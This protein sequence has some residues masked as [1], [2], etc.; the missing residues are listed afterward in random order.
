[1]YYHKVKTSRGEEQV[2]RTVIARQAN[3]VSCLSDQQSEAK[4]TTHPVPDVFEEVVDVEVLDSKR[5]D[6]HAEGPFLCE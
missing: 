4:E 3:E 2:T 6:P 5:I 1:M